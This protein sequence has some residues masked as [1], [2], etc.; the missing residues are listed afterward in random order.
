M[1]SG[2]SATLSENEWAVIFNGLQFAGQRM[3]L[4][5][6]NQAEAL[7]DVTINLISQIAVQGLM[8]QIESQD[9]EK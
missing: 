4:L 6:E 5:D 9:D 8:A 1:V 3:Y 2:R 7:L